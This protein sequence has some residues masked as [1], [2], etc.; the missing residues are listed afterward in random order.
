[1]KKHLVIFSSILI[2]ASLLSLS[3]AETEQKGRFMQEKM[4]QM[5]P[6]EGGFAAMSP[7]SRF[8][9]VVGKDTLY[10]YTAKDLKLKK[11]AYIGSADVKRLIGG[12]IFFSNDSKLLYIMRGKTLLLFDTLELNFINKVTIE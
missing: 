2:V 12:S 4:G 6:P 9:Y 11:S 3:Y 5:A 1:M 7:D 10:Q 8:V